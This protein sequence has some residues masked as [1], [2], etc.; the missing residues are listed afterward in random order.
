ASYDDR[1]GWKPD[2]PDHLLHAKIGR[3]FGHGIRLGSDAEACSGESPGARGT[4]GTV[5]R[6][7]LE[8]YLDATGPLPSPAYFAVGAYR[9]VGGNGLDAF[10]FGCGGT[11]RHDRKALRRRSSDACG[12]GLGA[13]RL[14]EKRERLVL[15]IAYWGQRLVH[16]VPC[17]GVAP[18]RPRQ[19]VQAYDLQ[20]EHGMLAHGLPG[21]TAPEHPRVQPGQARPPLRPMFEAQDAGLQ[22]VHVLEA[23]GRREYRQDFR[24]TAQ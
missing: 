2:L 11:F 4:G 22:R 20:P 17:S 13:G 15:V 5:L 6:R 21:E 1:F 16:V 8:F 9:S 3:A 24:E 23:D 12:G 7:T 10:G 18:D 19:P 14:G